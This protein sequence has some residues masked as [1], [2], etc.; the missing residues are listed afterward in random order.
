MAFD[1]L[2]KPVRALETSS[3]KGGCLGLDDLSIDPMVSYAA[4]IVEMSP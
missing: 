2:P 4:H 1:L 3:Q